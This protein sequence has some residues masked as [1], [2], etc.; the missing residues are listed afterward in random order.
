MGEHTEQIEVEQEE[1][2]GNENENH[3]DILTDYEEE[4]IDGNQSDIVE[5][6]LCRDSSQH[7]C[8]ICGKLVCNLFCSIM[9]PSSDDEQ[10]RI[11]KPGDSRCVAQSFECP[12]CGKKFKTSSDIE[13]HML[14]HTQETSL[15]LVSQAGSELE[16]L[17]AE[18]TE[19]EISSNVTETLEEFGIKQ[20]PYI[21]KRR[22]HNLNELDIDENGDIVVDEDSDDEF[23][24]SENYLPKRKKRKLEEKKM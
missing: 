11:H 13:A 1:I 7:H 4:E 18:E 14:N 16:R 10:Q 8:R 22:K 3:E 17:L 19:L 2:N 6:P 23:S 12:S 5:C 9:D 24:F 21:G 20:L 15:T